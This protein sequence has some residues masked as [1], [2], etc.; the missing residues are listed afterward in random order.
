MPTLPTSPPTV[1]GLSVVPNRTTGAATFS[2]DADTYMSEVNPMVS[3][4]NTAN[5]WANSTATQVYNN[6]VEAAGSASASAASATAALG[7][8][9][10]AADSANYKGI[11]SAQ[12]GA[13][14]K[15]YSVFHNGSF[16]ALNNNIA[17][18]ATSEP[19]LTNADWQ[20]ISGTRWQQTR[21]SS[22]TV[23]VNS[24][25][26]ILANGSPVGATLTASVPDGSFFAIAN[27]P[28]ST[29]TV[30]VLNAGY[31]IRSGNKTIT[32][33]DNIVLAA[34]QTIYLRA[35]SPTILEVLQN[36]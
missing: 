18:V 33:A 24:M 13:A 28:A 19:S 35:I 2:Q 10:L 36:G 20:F 21:T 8:Q 3:S 15:P 5:A 29:Q 22:F 23:P 11:W 4:Q 1:T 7:S 27:S 12:T 25:Q 30:R 9:L 26:A 17:N 32:N 14:N 16:W 6:A 31:T 34:G